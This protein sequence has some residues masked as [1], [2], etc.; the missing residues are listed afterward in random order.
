MIYTAEAVTRAHPDKVCDQISD[1][2]LDHCL[3][4]DPYARV[5]VETLGGHGQVTLMGEVTT[6]VP[7][8][9]ATCEHIAREVYR[10]NGYTDDISVS[11]HI[12]QQSPEIGAG[13]DN[14]GA[15]DQGVMVG[16]ATDETVTFMP[17]ELHLARLLTRAMGKHDGKAQVTVE[18]G[19]VTNVVTSLCESDDMS[20]VELDAI[21][22][23]EIA[24]YIDGPS[25]RV[26]LKNPNGV[27]KLGGFAADT[28]LTGR[29]IVIDA[30]GPRV[31]VGGGAFSGKDATKVDR[32]A[33]YMARK[34][35]VDYVRKGAHQATVTLAYAIGHPYP[36]AAVAH[37][38]GREELV[39]G[40]DLRPQAIIEQLG[41]RAPIYYKTAQS[42]H[43]GN[44]FAWDM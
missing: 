34:I 18:H 25:D 29:K 11:V 14:E 1:A 2:V 27:W 35:A 3:T 19:R 7:L 20:D 13:V 24:Q 10:D 8:D 44:G 21:F 28:G 12:S 17:L 40:Y 16:Y 31:Q 15:G 43:F 37:V 42:G 23:E 4:H 26:W 5:A 32:S 36:L 6:V 33:A 41:L 39:T 22:S 30:Y 9:N 38:D